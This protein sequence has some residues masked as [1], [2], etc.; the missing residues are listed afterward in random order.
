MVAVGHY[1]LSYLHGLPTK[2][3]KILFGMGELARQGQCTLLLPRANPTKFWNTIE[4]WRRLDKLVMW[5]SFFF[6]WKQ[7]FNDWRLMHVQSFSKLNFMEKWSFPW[8]GNR[9]VNYTTIK[10]RSLLQSLCAIYQ[11]IF[12]N[13]GNETMLGFVTLWHL[14]KT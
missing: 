5:L 11:W 2:M 4:N 1:T 12:S 10:N 7:L 8:S 3:E 14:S 6:I 9:P 13:H